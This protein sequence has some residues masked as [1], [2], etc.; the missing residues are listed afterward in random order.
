MI[1]SV[2]V[3]GQY[4]QVRSLHD[5]DRLIEELMTDLAPGD[6]W[7]NTDRGETAELYLADTALTAETF[8]EPPFDWQA[9]SVLTVSVNSVT[10]LG[11]LRWNMKLASTNPVPPQDP[12]VVF[13][14]E[15]PY[16]FHPRHVLPT[17]RIMA[18]VREFRAEQG[19]LPASIEWSEFRRTAGS[20]VD[21]NQYRS[22]FPKA[23]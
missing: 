12:R 6:P 10:G 17:P 20:Y 3:H 13:D 5:L 15:V 11:A 4:R 18:A 7:T 14:P 9:H 22:L 19:S 23:A 2:A 21:S 8:D 1:L 16:W